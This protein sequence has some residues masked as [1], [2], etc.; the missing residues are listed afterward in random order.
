MIEEQTSQMN[1]AEKVLFILLG[2]LLGMLSPIILDTIR[3]RQN[4]S[5]FRAAL[6][7]EVHELRYR[8]ACVTY[9]VQL[10]YGKVNKKLLTWIKPILDDY[11]GLN[12]VN[13]IRNS[14]EKQLAMTDEQLKEFAKLGKAAPEVGLSLKK[15]HLPLLDSRISFISSLDAALQ[16][17]L[18]EVKTHLNVLNEEVDQARFYYNLTFQSNI[19]DKDHDRAVENLVNCYKQFGERAKI[20]VD[21]IR[22]IRL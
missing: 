12:P 3:K 9:M 11:K 22:E 19:T 17:Q 10:K 16:N 14:I 15:F 20:I 7:T 2:W 21:L 1:T 4:I 18:L 5:E 8:L 6:K 13:D